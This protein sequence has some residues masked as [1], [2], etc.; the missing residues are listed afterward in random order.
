MN[1][2]PKGVRDSRRATATTL[3]LLKNNSL[4]G[5]LLKN[6]DFR[7]LIADITSVCAQKFYEP[8]RLEQRR[9]V[10]RVKNVEHNVESQKIKN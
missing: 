3:K 7:V 4:L 1:S 5:L 9:V 2:S 8:S 6:G 10:P